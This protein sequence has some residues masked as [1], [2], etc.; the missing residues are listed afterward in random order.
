VTGFVRKSL[1]LVFADPEL[2]GFEVRARR[3]SIGQLLDLS[4][5]RHIAGARDVTDEVREAM[6]GVFRT[7]AGI[8]LDWNLE[9]PADLA[10]PDGPTQK[11]P[12]TADTLAAQDFGLVMA[13]VDAIQDATTAVPAALKAK[14][15]GGVPSVEALLPMEPLSEN[16]PS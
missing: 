10:D 3:L 1:R 12:L 13:I 6:A 11:V 7:L 4:E 15:S 14:S 9:E 16:Q 5:L 8:L 2:E